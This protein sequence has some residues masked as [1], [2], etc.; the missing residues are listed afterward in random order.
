[1][2]GGF[3]VPAHDTACPGK[4]ADP[5]HRVLD[6]CLRE[7]PF[8]FY[9]TTLAIAL[10]PYPNCCH[11]FFSRSRTFHK[12]RLM[13][14]QVL[15]PFGNDLHHTGYLCESGGKRELQ[16]SITTIHLSQMQEEVYPFR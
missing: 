15:I 9:F 7:M 6:L 12:K 5:S 3:F 16:L 2:P 8:L 10:K 11:L 13:K 14:K 4:D 1:M